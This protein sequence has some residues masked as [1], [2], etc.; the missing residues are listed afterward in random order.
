MYNG[1]NQF[2][3]QQNQQWQQGTSGNFGGV[4][5]L[6]NPLQAVQ[7]QQAPVQP[8]Y[9]LRKPPVVMPAL[10]EPAPQSVSVSS[11]TLPLTTLASARAPRPL[12]AEGGV[13]LTA[14]VSA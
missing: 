6:Q 10:H 11:T 1:G 9:Q 4:S 2:A 7:Q 12:A 8:Q 3:A 14:G 5:G 13:M